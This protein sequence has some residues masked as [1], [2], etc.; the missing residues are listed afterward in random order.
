MKTTVHT[1][2]SAPAPSQPLLENSVKAF[3]RLPSL[4]AVMATSPGLLE[5]YQTLHRLAIDATAFDPTERTVV[6]QTVNV[7]HQCHYCV[8]A[9]TAIAKMEKIDGAVVEALRNE[10]PLA[11][12][13][14]EA[15]RTFTLAVVD[16]RGRP[17][18]SAIAAF[19][20]AGY[21]E[22]AILD[23]VLIVAQKVMSNYTNSLF[24]TPTD[25][26]FEAYAWSPT[27]SRAAA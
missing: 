6:W 22:R 3:G 4:H 27:G 20:A 5:G 14:L 2:E 11:D 9:H 13:K 7:R 19:E 16:S 12:P 24:E 26:A 21:G 23:I 25:A 18:Q 15:L 17:S 8:P 10:T 1:L